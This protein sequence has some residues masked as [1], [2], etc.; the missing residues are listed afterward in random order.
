MAEQGHQR[1]CRSTFKAAVS[2]NAPSKG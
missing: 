1:L 2:M